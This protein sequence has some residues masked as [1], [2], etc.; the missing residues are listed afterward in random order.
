[1]GPI[2]FARRFFGLYTPWNVNA[3]CTRPPGHP[4]CRSVSPPC[5]WPVLAGL[6]AASR[7]AR[8]A[9]SY[10]PQRSHRARA[11]TGCLLAALV[12]RRLQWSRGTHLPSLRPSPAL[13][14]R[15]NPWGRNQIGSCTET[16]D[17]CGADPFRF[18][19]LRLAS[20]CLQSSCESGRNDTLSASPPYV[21]AHILLHRR[22]SPVAGATSHTRL[23]VG[24]YSAPFSGA[25]A[26][27]G[28]SS[29]RAGRAVHQSQFDGND[30]G[31][32][33]GTLLAAHGG[34]D[35][36]ASTVCCAVLWPRCLRPCFR[37]DSGFRRWPT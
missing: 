34:L 10:P 36:A 23:P 13:A 33:P 26:K 4:L 12:S 17:D 14:G 8:R 3:F 29:R 27:L 21:D 35:I 6:R 2:R 7:Y 11:R 30:R 19:H 15:R 1:M 22:L 16:C 5:R 24:I 9:V 18:Q 31:G 32:H 37:Q 25:D 28:C 20:I